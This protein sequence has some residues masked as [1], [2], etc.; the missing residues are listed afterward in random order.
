[1]SIIERRIAA[2]EQARPDNGL[3]KTIIVSFQMPGEPAT[4]L[5]KLRSS[6]ADAAYLEWLRGPDE[7]EQAFIDR[8]SKE[9]TRNAGGIA[10]LFK[11]L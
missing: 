10:T 6:T 1:M 11:C 4:E 9:S 7:T 8:A 2:L 5:H 3:P